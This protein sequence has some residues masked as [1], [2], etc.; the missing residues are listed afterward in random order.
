MDDFLAG[1]GGLG[2]K[3]AK[4]LLS[5][6]IYS[7]LEHSCGYYNID[8]FNNMTKNFTST[9]SISSLNIRSLAKK[10]RYT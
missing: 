1:E 6:D 2:E 7:N 10:I 5:K 3:N 9:F 8:K 4:Q